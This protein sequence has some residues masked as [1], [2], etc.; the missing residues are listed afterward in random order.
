MD[1]LTIAIVGQPNVGKS[2]LINAL[3]NAQ[4]KVGNFAGVTVEAKKI[5]SIF[6]YKNKDYKIEL[7]D[8]PGIYSLKDFTTEEKVTKNFLENEEYDL[9]L[10]IVDATH[11][12]RSLM[13][14]AQLMELGKKMVVALNMMDEAKKE[15]IEINTK[16]LSKI[17]GV[18]VVEVSAKTKEG[19]E[20]LKEKIIEAAHSNIYPKMVYSDYI[21]EEI[22]KIVNFLKEKHFKFRLPLRNL[23]I[24]L[25]KEDRNIY[26][27]LHDEPIWIE[28]LPLIRSALE[29]IYLHAQAQDIEEIFTQEYIAFAKGAKEEVLKCPKRK[30]K[31]IT[32]KIDSILLN[33]YLGIPIFLIL[34]W[35]LFQA[36][37]TLGEVPV[38][39]L[40][41][42]F[43]SLTNYIKDSYPNSSFTPLIAD[44]IIKGV[45]GVIEFLPNIIILFIGIALLETTGYMARVSFL[46]DGF[47]HKFGLHGKSFIPLI[48][49]FGCT[50]PAYMAARTLKNRSDR[51]ITMFILSFFSCSARVP[52]YVLFISI[53]FPSNIAGNA[54]FI[55]YITGAI[56]GLIAAKIL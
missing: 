29:H 56:L 25:L 50:V 45:G 55:I 7:I 32:Q 44:G 18:P 42:L 11:L 27:E 28:L 51:L 4:L 1:T 35:L 16:L 2:S 17:L 31:N 54:L 10:N 23:A 20:E 40:D 47:F 3:T 37:F 49:G 12:Q 15:G 33:K 36:T 19:I 9:I 13:L 30:S 21:E 8:L 34:M 52:V 24:L 14:T 38:E 6:K 46:L 53:F 48:T 39:L 22:D 26:K 41:N 5:E 43:N